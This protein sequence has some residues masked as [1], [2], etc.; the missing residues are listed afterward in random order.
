MKHTLIGLRQFLT[1]SVI[2]LIP[3]IQSLYLILKIR[4]KKQNKKKHD[5][6]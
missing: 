4:L 2:I 5:K 1:R 3:V 6:V